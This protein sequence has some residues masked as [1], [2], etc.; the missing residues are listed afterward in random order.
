MDMP[1]SPRRRATT[2]S[3]SLTPEL[4]AAVARRVESGLYT[5]A[6]E[7]IREALRLLISREARAGAFGAD[8]ESLEPARLAAAVA[9]MEQGAE[10]RAS[11]RQGDPDRN[12]TGDLLRRL[13]EARQV[14]PG[15]RDAPERLRRL[16]SDE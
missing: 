7:L 5:S 2:L 15:L 1:P 3:I 16:R 12:E 10:L 11:K 6:S 14:G 9:L 13:E 4:A 8:L